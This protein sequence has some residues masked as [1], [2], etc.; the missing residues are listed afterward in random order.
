MRERGAQSQ[1]VMT[2]CRPQS[3][4]TRLFSSALGKAASSWIC[5]P[6]RIIVS[7]VEAAEVASRYVP[8]Q[9]QNPISITKSGVSASAR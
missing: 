7:M 9:A 5:V 6:I 2:T 3:W 1:E 4:E 8:S